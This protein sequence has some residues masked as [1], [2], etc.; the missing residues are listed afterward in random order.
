MNYQMVIVV[1]AAVVSVI[2][3]VRRVINDWRNTQS[4]GC[5]SCPVNKTEPPR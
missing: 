1:I 5:T 4:S 2:Y 3:V